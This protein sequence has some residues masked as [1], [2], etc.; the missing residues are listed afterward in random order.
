[1][2]HCLI[3]LSSPIFKKKRAR[4]TVQRLVVVSKTKRKHKIREKHFQMLHSS[5]REEGRS[6]KTNN[7]A[8]HKTLMR[9]QCADT[10]TLSQIPQFHLGLREKKDPVSVVICQIAQAQYHSLRHTRVLWF[11]VTSPSQEPE[12]RV[13]RLVVCLAMQFTP[14]LWP[15]RAAKKGLA[16]TLSS[17][18]ALRARVYSLHT[19]NGWRLGS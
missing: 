14:S 13:Q 10:V 3:V 12:S 17:L 18:V 9:L 16:S 6:T 1:M 19:S 2:F 15:S 11:T 4:K 5:Y 7:H 8:P